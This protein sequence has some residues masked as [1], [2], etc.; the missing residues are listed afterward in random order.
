VSSDITDHSYE[1]VTE[2][3]FSSLGAGGLKGDWDWVVGLFGFGTEAD[4]LIVAPA[5]IRLP[6]GLAP[7]APPDGIFVLDV[8][9]YFERSAYSV[10]VFLD[11]G[12]MLTDELRFGFGFR[13]SHDWKESLRISPE[14]S[15][16]GLVPIFEAVN[17][18]RS[19]EWGK[20]SFMVGLDYQM[21][22]EHMIYGKFSSGYK[23]GA[24]VND[25]PV[26]GGGIFE[27][28]EVDPEDI[29]ALEFGLKQTFLDGRMRLS[30]SVFNYWYSNLQVSQIKESQI[31]IENAD[32]ART[33]GAEVEAFYRPWDEL[34]LIATFSYLDAKFGNFI[35]CPSAEEPSRE[36]I[37]C[38]GNTLPRS[39]EFTGSFIA[40]YDFD[41]ARY[42]VLTPLVQVFASSQVYF[43]ATNLPIDLQPAYALLNVRLMWRSSE[44]HVSVEGF[45]ENVTDEDV[46]TTKIVGSSL[47]GSPV[48]TAYDRPRTAGIR[49]GLNW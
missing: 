34:T 10:A 41:M 9:Q 17:D 5:N 32:D 27:G 33:F 15:L 13:Y 45:L 38:T 46:G 20:P 36:D 14:N 11:T 23:S 22:E 40:M 35:G 3:N 29:Y 47:L 42:G 26:L 37:D 25:I 30:T 39:P 21:L 43:R 28:Y 24:L 18:S 7:I 48:F 19:G 31:V 2:I 8:E 1:W 12:Y 6:L 4:Q 16:A 49:V 44:G